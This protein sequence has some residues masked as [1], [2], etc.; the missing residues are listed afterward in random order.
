MGAGPWRQDPEPKGLILLL[1]LLKLLRRPYW[2]HHGNLEQAGFIGGI[3]FGSFSELGYWG[4]WSPVISL[5]FCFLSYLMF[6]NQAPY[7]AA[8]F[9]RKWGIDFWT[10]WCLLLL[11]ILPADDAWDDYSDPP[12]MHWK[13]TQQSRVGGK[14]SRSLAYPELSHKEF[15]GWCVV[16]RRTGQ[17]PWI[18]TSFLAVV[19]LYVTERVGL[20]THIIMVII[21]SGGT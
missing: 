12:S 18:F 9:Q 5:S 10:F 1:L 7:S 3:W 6:Q 21:C 17:D 19:P 20:R 13:A 15:C 2:L 11:Y 16:R 4:A 8:S 14:E